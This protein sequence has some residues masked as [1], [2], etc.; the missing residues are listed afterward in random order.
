MGGGQLDH[1]VVHW[2]RGDAQSDTVW[3]CD[4][5]AHVHY[6]LFLLVLSQLLQD[7]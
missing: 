3:Q 5:T 7:F 4:K 6:G 1:G 2:K